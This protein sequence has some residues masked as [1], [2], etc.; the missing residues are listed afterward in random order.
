MGGFSD[1]VYYRGYEKGWQEGLKEAMEEATLLVSVNSIKALMENNMSFT[2]ACN[3]LNITDPLRDQCLQLIS[4]EICE[5][6][7]NQ[8]NM[9]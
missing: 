2:D 7:D 8:F 4:T 6:T 5:I 3:L 9:T 1:A